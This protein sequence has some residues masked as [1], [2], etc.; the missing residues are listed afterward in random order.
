MLTDNLENVR[1][2]IFDSVSIDD[3]LLFI[4]RCRKLEQ[5]K[6]SQFYYAN[7][8]HK[9]I[10]DLTALNNERKKLEGAKKIRIFI[11]EDIFLLNKWKQE[12]NLSLIELKR[13]HS[14]EQSN[15]FYP[16]D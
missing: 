3:I 4:R 13:E 2:I 9:D 6:I 16:D 14:W 1:R 8:R 5:I 15:I 12:I 11:E 7:Y 10:I